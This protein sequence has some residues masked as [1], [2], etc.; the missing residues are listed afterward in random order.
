[1][2]TIV[3]LAGTGRKLASAA[4]ACELYAS[5]LFR[6]NLAFARTF[7]PDQTHILSARHG[8]LALDAVVDPYPT[9]L[10]RLPVAHLQLWASQVVRQLEAVSDLQEDHFV[11]LA[12]QHY[13]KLLEP[14]L[15]SFEVPMRGISAQRQVGL[16]QAYRR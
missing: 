8:L 12:G 9:T 11:F 4:A 6:L 2:K 16:L 7:H 3:L 15:A 1:V 13:R 14:H 10:E 5:P